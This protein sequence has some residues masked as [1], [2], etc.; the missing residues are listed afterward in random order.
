MNITKL[1]I[2]I[3]KN[4][5]PV[6]ANEKVVHITEK[7]QLQFYNPSK[8]KITNLKLTITS[9]R[10]MLTFESNEAFNFEIYYNKVKDYRLDK[11]GFIYKTPYRINLE[12]FSGEV[13][14]LKNDSRGDVSRE[15]SIIELEYN[16]KLWKNTNMQITSEVNVNN[17]GKDPNYY[18]LGA[19]LNQDKAKLNINKEQAMAYLQKFEGIFN[20]FDELKD[21]FAYFKTNNTEDYEQDQTL[22]ELMNNLGQNTIV[23]KEGTTSEYHL[24]LAKEIS[25][26]FENHLKNGNGII[27]VIDAFALYNTFRGIDLITPHDF[28]EALNL[29]GAVNSAL[30]CEEIK[31]GVKILRLIDYNAYSYF[32]KT[33]LP[34]IQEAQ[35]NAL[36]QEQL[37]SSKQISISLARIILDLH[38][39]NGFLCLDDHISG[40]F[41]YINDLLNYVSVN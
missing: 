21:L 4:L 20:Y 36:S 31:D 11:K 9:H 3:D 6:I 29:L 5:S 18:G 41:Y 17:S 22:K 32:E 14:Q 35:D 10:I 33:I 40:R 26:V 7:F 19:Q 8:Q 2:Q 13:F 23:S 27:S 25:R 16:K 12:L 38:C 34:Y 39:Q 28:L 37:A 1:S 24:E 30:V 15:F